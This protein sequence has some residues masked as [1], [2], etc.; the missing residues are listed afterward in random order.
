MA[1][2]SI[3]GIAASGPILPSP[4]TAL[5]SVMIATALRLIGQV[6]RP[7]RILDDCHADP[8]DPWRVHHRQVIARPDRETRGDLDLAAEMRKKGPIRV[9]EHLH[10]GH[11]RHCLDQLLRMVGVRGKHGDVADDAVP[12]HPNDVERANV[13]A[14]AA[15]G[16]GELPEHPRP[17]EDAAPSR[18][19][20]ARRRVPDH[21]GLP[22]LVPPHGVRT[23]RRSHAAVARSRRLQT[24]DTHERP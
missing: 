20:E 23:Y 13:P 2:P 8:R 5:P 24:R 21:R 14:A 7:T 9:L 6:S 19:R 11:R 16:G 15:D 10:T 17:V 4:S 3:T 12:V 18:E 22:A 1:F